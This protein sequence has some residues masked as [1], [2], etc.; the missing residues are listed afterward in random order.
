MDRKIIAALQ[1]SLDGLIEGPEAGVDWIRQLGRPIRG[2]SR[3]R[4]VHRRRGH[5]PR[6]RAVLAV[7][8]CRPNRRPGLDR[9]ATFRRGGR[10]CTIRRSDPARRAL[11]NT[12]CR[13][14]EAGADRS[15]RQGDPQADVFDER[16]AGSFPTSR[17]LTHRGDASFE[18]R[19]THWV[20]NRG[21]GGD[22]RPGEA[23]CRTVGWPRHRQVPRLLRPVTPSAVRGS[24]HRSRSG[25]KETARRRGL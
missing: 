12:R 22:L 23:L 20:P 7:D 17:D 4:H 2:A 13:E 14:L 24:G 16:G 1:V 11:E 10:L 3:D 19:V 15:R 8:P 25:N 18:P 5:V 9:T 21:S 6:I